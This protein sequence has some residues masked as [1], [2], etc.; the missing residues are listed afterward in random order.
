VKL[1]LWNKLDNFEW[2]L[3]AVYGAAKEAEKNIF[4][5]ELV[6]TCNVGSVPI[7]VGGDFNI[8]RSP[9]EKNNLRYNDR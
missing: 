8:I 9:S 6:Q 2:M 7:M 5:H 4:L 3:V 1:H